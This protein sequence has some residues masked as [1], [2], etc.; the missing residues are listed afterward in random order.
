[1]GVLDMRAHNNDSRSPRNKE[2]SVGI[3]TLPGLFNYGNRLQ[4]Y[5]VFTLYQKLGYSPVVLERR[6]SR[7]KRL[8]KR[9]LGRHRETR[10]DL[11]DPQ[12]LARFKSFNARM[13]HEAVSRPYCLL[14]QRYGY[15][16]V[17]SDQ[18][19][20]PEWISRD[21][22]WYFLRFARKRQ[23]IALAP[24][25]GVD[26]L[27]DE[28]SLIIASGVDGFPS[29]SVRERRGAELIRECSGRDALVVC[30]PTLTLEDVDW[31]A[32]SC[33]D[34]TP[35]DPYVLSYVLGGE[36]E[37]AT[38]ILC[39]ISGNNETRILALSD[40]NGY[41]EL[42]AGPAEFISLIDK[43]QHVVT[44]SFHAAVFASILQTPL[45]I[46]R[47]E[48]GASMFSRLEQ[49]SHTL[50]IT[51]KVYGSPDFDLSRADDYEG[52]AVAIRQERKKLISY[53]E[54]CLDD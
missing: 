50:H 32:V 21:T 31:R 6:K 1:M 54:A 9:L 7:V 44:D 23:R 37:A 49:L 42:P 40:G 8:I 28:G 33:D 51:H 38:D 12:R 3:V 17:G 41:G 25:I 24:S 5:A 46:I 13:R 30:D 52:V 19:W 16:S 27:S 48:G 39:R 4:C 36:G 2:K 53:L 35:T 43:A 34:L 26:R 18:T 45:T 22:D 11:M 10:E 47:R 14:K 29:L 20:N 15:F